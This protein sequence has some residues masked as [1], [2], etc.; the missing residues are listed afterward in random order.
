MWTVRSWASSSIT[1]E[2]LHTN[3][4]WYCCCCCHYHYHITTTD[5]TTTTLTTTTTTTMTKSTTITTTTIRLW[6]IKTCYFY[7]PVPDRLG[8]GVLFSIDFFIC[9]YICIFVS[10]LAR[11]RE[12]GWT[13][14]HE[15]FRECVEWPWDDLITY[16]V[17][18]EK[19]CDAAM[20]NTGTGFVVLSHHSLLL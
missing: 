12:N 10:L 6:S 14:L 11:L 8:Y 15:I 13:D 2:Y 17:N 20:R 16:L 5:I 1:T 9:M 7:Y 19:P 3:C 18:S 4:S